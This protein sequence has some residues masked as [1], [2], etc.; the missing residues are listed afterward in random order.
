MNFDLQ[1]QLLSLAAQS[2]KAAVL[3]RAAVCEDCHSCIPQISD[4]NR[5]ALSDLAEA[6]RALI[7]ESNQ[8][9]ALAAVQSLAACISHAFSAALLVPQALPVLPP[10]AEIVSANELLATYLK[11]ILEC[12]DSSGFYPLHLCANKGRGAHAILIT[13]YCAARNDFSLLPLALALENHRNAL[14]N[15]CGRLMLLPRA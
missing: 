14:E 11:Q 12:R 5:Q 10:L 8:S 9:S 15:A 13:H 4:L 1:K 2:Q 3:L 6:E 7:S